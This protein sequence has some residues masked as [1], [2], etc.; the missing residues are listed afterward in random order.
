MV[1]KYQT[2]ATDR[3]IL[4]IALPKNTHGFTLIAIHGAWGKILLKRLGFIIFLIQLLLSV[5]V[6]QRVHN[7][8][9]CTRPRSIG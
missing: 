8:K 5:K 2:K 3:I 9:Y 1:K 7:E 4:P 6:L